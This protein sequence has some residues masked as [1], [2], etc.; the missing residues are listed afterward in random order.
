MIW[1]C[2]LHGPKDT[3]YEGG[4]FHV[5]IT[6]TANYPFK[7]P[8]V[9]F[10]TRIYHPNISAAGHVCMDILKHNW[11]PVFGIEKILLSISSILSAPNPNDPLDI[12]I[13]KHMTE[14]PESFAERA[15]EYTKLYA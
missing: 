5:C 7:P 2:V 13:G 11:S 4:R 10:K 12:A 6:P 9:M 8:I 3:P 15:R 1:D 14:D